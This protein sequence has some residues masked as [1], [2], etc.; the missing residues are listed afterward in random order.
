VADSLS[1]QTVILHVLHCRE[2][3][4]S[5]TVPNGESVLPLQHPFGGNC[6]LDGD[7]V[8]SF[9]GSIPLLPGTYVWVANVDL[10]SMSRTG[11]DR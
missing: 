3:T 10:A 5:R 11:G 8:P 6:S 2:L 4:Q 9:S 1:L 7:A